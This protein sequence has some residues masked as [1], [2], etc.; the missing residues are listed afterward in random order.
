[1]SQVILYR[2]TLCTWMLVLLLNSTHVS[3]SENLVCV[4]SG[5]RSMTIT[6]DILSFTR[7]CVCDREEMMRMFLL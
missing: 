6:F 7:K 5:Y 1:M 3:Q 4:R 2:V